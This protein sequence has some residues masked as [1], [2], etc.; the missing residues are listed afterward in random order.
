MVECFVKEFP[1]RS[2][3]ASTRHVLWT[4]PGMLGL[5]GLHAQSLAAAE[6][7]YQ[8]RIRAT[9]MFGGASCDGSDTKIEACNQQECPVDCQWSSW[10]Q[11]SDCSKSCDLGSMSRSRSRIV[12]EDFGGLPCQ[13]VALQEAEC[14]RE[15][16]A[17]DCEWG[18]WSRWTACSAHCDD[19]ITKRFRDVLVTAKNDGLPCIG[20][21]EEQAVCHESF[22]PRD[23]EWDDLGCMD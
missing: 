21:D 7:K 4:V 19:G 17:V 18:P 9:Q 11:W 22:C 14:N 13:G 15:G 23:C 12:T 1:R 10:T 20:E 3:A 16:C 6:R 8:H 2:A 5:I